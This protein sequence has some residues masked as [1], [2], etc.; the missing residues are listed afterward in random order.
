[1]YIE[2]SAKLLRKFDFKTHWM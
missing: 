2:F 1:M